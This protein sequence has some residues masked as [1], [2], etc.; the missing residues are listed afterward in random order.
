MQ[1]G[2]WKPCHKCLKRINF[3]E[4]ED[5]I[6]LKDMVI[7]PLCGRDYTKNQVQ[8]LERFRRTI[9]FFNHDELKKRIRSLSAEMGDWVD[10][11]ESQ[12]TESL[13]Q[14][15]Q[16]F[17]SNEILLVEILIDNYAMRDYRALRDELLNLYEKNL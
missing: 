1:R 8:K 12:K 17:L 4:I 13:E 16:A 6:Q 11:I 14:L 9:S 7:C 2:E 15:Q 5:C 3:K 10:G